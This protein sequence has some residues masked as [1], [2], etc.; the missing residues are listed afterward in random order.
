MFFDNLDKNKIK[1]IIG[2]YGKQLGV[3]LSF[4]DELYGK[5]F[6]TLIFLDKAQRIPDFNIDKS[7][8]GLMS[9]WITVK[10]IDSIKE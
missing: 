5:N 10:D 4:A 3:P 1:Q 6:C 2:K 9:A 8:F 7:G